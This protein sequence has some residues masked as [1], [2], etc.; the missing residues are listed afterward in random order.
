VGEASIRDLRNHGA[1]VIGGVQAGESRDDHTRRGSGRRASTV[2]KA[3]A[4]R[5]HA[6]RAVSYPSPVD[7]ERLRADVDAVIDQSL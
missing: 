4:W 5:E 1:E 6:H 3:A 2:A 7:A